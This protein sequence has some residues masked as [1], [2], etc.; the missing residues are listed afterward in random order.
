ME[1]TQNAWKEN[2]HKSNLHCKQAYI[3]PCL[4]GEINEINKFL[5]VVKIAYNPHSC[6]LQINQKLI[7]KLLLNNL[8]HAITLF[9]VNFKHDLVCNVWLCF[10][11]SA[12]ISS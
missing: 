7:Y 2:S 11:N 8:Q 6:L 4:K 12:V 1:I 5:N 3:C 9:T 10:M